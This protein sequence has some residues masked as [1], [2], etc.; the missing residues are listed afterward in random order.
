[1]IKSRSS[2]F[3]RRIRIIVSQSA[4]GKDGTKDSVNYKPEL[5]CQL[6]FVFIIRIVLS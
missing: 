3:V 1:M 2:L 6:A 4:L 5:R